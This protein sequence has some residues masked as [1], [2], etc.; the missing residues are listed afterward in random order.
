MSMTIS[1]LLPPYQ[2][3]VEQAIQSHIELIGPPSKVRDACL[4]ALET[5]GK[6]FRP[7]LVMM[8]AE[9]LGADVNLDYA[10]FAVECFHT[11]S[12]IADDLPCM[13]NDPCRRDCPSTH[14]K[15]GEETALLATY[16][17]IAAGYD[18][19]ARQSESTP[20]LTSLA[21]SCASQ[22]TGLYGATGGQYFDLHPTNDSR[23]ELERV[24]LL[25]TVS[26]FELS[27]V[28]GW[29]FGGGD[30]S[31]LP[32]VRKLAYDFGMAFQIADDLDDWDQDEI[33]L[34]KLLGREK[35]ATVLQEHL[36]SFF[37]N[38]ALLGLNAASFKA[39]AETLIKKS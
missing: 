7:A 13:D 2:K 9:G 22:T 6:R 33:N 35:T 25:K 8:V 14:I 27:F 23:E 37:Q 29:I 17:L 1:N 30:I 21:I 38:S 5:G 10:S 16:A 31:K 28:L 34:A 3:R 36:T 19:L 4:Y 26:L 20:H 18:A 32:G 24:I 15:F 11:A 39:L 12:L